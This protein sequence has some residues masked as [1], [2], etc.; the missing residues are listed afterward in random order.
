[1]FLRNYICMTSFSEDGRLIVHYSRNQNT[2]YIT[3]YG[4]VPIPVLFDKETSYLL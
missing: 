2:G 1:M 3:E 4:S